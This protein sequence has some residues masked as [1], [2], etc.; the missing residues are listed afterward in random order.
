VWR[1]IQDATAGHRAGATGAMMD[2]FERITGFAESDCTSMQARMAVDGEF[3]VSKVNDSRHRIGQ[4]EVVTLQALRGRRDFARSGGR[5]TTARCLVAGARALH[6]QPE[7]AGATFQVASQFN[8]LEMVGPSVP[9][10][11]PA[12][13][14]SLSHEG[15]PQA[16]VARSQPLRSERVGDIAIAGGG[17]MALLTDR[18]AD[19]AVGDPPG[20]A[21]RLD[22]GARGRDASGRRQ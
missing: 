3:L 8:L 17:A 22:A 20:S 2:W 10:R 16:A 4:L 7:F 18:R 19:E 6:A 14:A 1:F 21:I 11:I 9:G 13:N 12:M 5:R 15:P